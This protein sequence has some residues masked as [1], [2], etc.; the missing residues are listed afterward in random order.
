MQFDDTLGART[1]SM[2]QRHGE[3]IYQAASGEEDSR[4]Y[5]DWSNEAS[6]D[7]LSTRA[8]HG[9]CDPVHQLDV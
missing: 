7:S 2:Q 6:E 3:L 5:S 8:P 4:S 1:L 9:M